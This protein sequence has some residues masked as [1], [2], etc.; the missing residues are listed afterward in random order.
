M[1]DTAVENRITSDKLTE[2]QKF[3]VSHGYDRRARCSGSTAT[4]KTVNTVNV[5]ATCRCG[6]NFYTPRSTTIRVLIVTE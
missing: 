4:V 5:L 3:V 6:W 1:N 2:G